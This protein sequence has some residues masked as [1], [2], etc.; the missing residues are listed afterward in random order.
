[1]IEIDEPLP[2]R[3]VCILWHL[4]SKRI[5][6]VTPF[7]SAALALMSSQMEMGFNLIPGGKPI[8][9]SK[10]RT[11]DLLTLPPEE[12]LSFLYHRQSGAVVKITKSRP[13]T[14]QQLKNSLLLTAR[15]KNLQRVSRVIT[16]SRMRVAHSEKYGELVDYMRREQAL[17]FRKSGYNE[18]QV[19]DYL[20]VFQ[21]AQVKK[22]SSREAADEIIFH[23]GLFEAALWQTEEIKLKYFDLISNAATI[24]ENNK[25]FQDFIR[26]YY[27]NSHV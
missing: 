20:F 15:V 3:N 22:I 8:L 23:F 2:R 17:A 5:L 10:V 4:K 1:M 21:Y 13:P 24:E 18:E 16:Q 25:I 6:C 19:K 12:L 14:E 27:L 7:T 9:H 11:A 26:E